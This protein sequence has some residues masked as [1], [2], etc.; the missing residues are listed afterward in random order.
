[1]LFLSR[2]FVIAIYCFCFSTA[3]FG[4]D[5]GSNITINDQNPLGVVGWVPAAEDGEVEP[6]MQDKQI[7]DL[8]GV[9]LDQHNV[10]SMVGGFNFMSGA[11]GYEDKYPSGDIFLATKSK[12]D[13]EATTR[14]VPAGKDNFLVNNSYGYDFVFDL[15]FNGVDGGAYSLFAI[16][17]SSM[18]ETAYYPVNE[19]SSPWQ[20][21]SSDNP[22]NLA[23]LE[24]EFWFDF[25]LSDTEV[26]FLGDT[27]DAPNSHYLL[28]GF[29]LSFLGGAN[30]FY[31]H[32][33][34]G[35]GNDNLMGYG[36]TVPT[37]EPS[38]F[39][40]MGV[41]GGLLWFARRRKART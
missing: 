20:Y 26:G 25:G 31:A 36:E 40:L 33:T 4:L 8:E 30:D 14:T 11:P 34:M 38:T 37:P 16:D 1:M 19:G 24:G 35:C 7:W 6:G 22:N 10:L 27:A 15:T 39:L 13:Y 17:G 3:A 12:P 32:F 23:V 28:T 41:G 5:I 21:N 2:L 9:F 29:D 18:V